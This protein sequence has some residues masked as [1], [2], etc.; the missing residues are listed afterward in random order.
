MCG[1]AGIHR[2]GA[3]PI[4]Q[5]GKLANE[6]L[7][8]I[9]DRGRDSTGY[10][11]IRADGK[12]QTQKALGPASRFVRT[13]GRFD[14]DFRTLLL[15]TRFATRGAKVVSNAHPIIAGSCAAVHNGTI[16]NHA[17]VFA[18]LDVR[19]RFSVDSEI[20]P[21]SVSKIGWD[22]A[23]RALSLLDGGMATAV[24][25]NERPD[26]LVLARLRSYP[27][28][29]L[30]T[31]DLVVFASTRQ[32]IE[33]AWRATYG[34]APR[35]RWVEVGDFEV[36]RINGKIT[37]EPIEARPVG[38]AAPL[39]TKLKFAKPGKPVSGSTAARRRKRSKKEAADLRRAVREA[40]QTTIR[41]AEDGALVDETPDEFEVEAD[42]V[43]QHVVDLMRWAKVD[44][45]E[46]EEMIW[47]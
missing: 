2:R 32:A 28:V 1:I 30:V 22:D 46:A 35:G 38:R 37:V 33:R 6:L 26:E 31:R 14:G 47:G 41:F 10:L 15:H 5:A 24:V 44:R 11:A 9:E 45:A 36:H 17:E 20:I 18:K 16:F 39:P 27:L 12:V 13:R 19:R 43:E 42:F 34:K 4:E 40:T 25:T 21:A 8:A 23:A 7:L 3:A 29:Y